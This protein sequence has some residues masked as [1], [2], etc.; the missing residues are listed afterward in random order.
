MADITS[1]RNLSPRRRHRTYP[2]VVKRARR[3]SYPVKTLTDI[4]TRHTGPPTISIARTS[5]S[6]TLINSS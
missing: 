3:N 6:G 2:R 5:R 4:G 1:S